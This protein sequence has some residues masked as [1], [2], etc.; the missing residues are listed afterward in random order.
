MM[1][2]AC[3]SASTVPSGTANSIQ[4][5]K[6]CQALGQVGGEVRLWLPGEC[7]VGWEALAEQ[8]GLVT[9][10][11]VRWLAARARLRRYDFAWQALRAARAWGAQAVY[12]WVPQAAL[13]ALWMGLPALLELHDRPTGKVGPWL[14]RQVARH[15]GR[16]RLLFITR[17]LQTALE[18]EQGVKVRPGEAI[19][20]PDGVDVERYPAGL[21]APEARRS[22]GLP[23]GITAGY[24]GHLY[25]GRGM[26][27]LIALAQAYPGVNFLWIGGRPNDV[28]QWRT[29]AAQMGLANLTL[30]GFVPNRQIPLYQAAGDI[31]L[32]PYETSVSVSGGGNT[33]DVCSPMKMF[34]YMAA[35]RAILSSDLPVLHEVLDASRAV[36]C[37]PEDPGAWVETFG[38]LMRDP[39]RRERLGAAARAAVGA[40]SWQERA[41]R[42][43]EE[44]R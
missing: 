30:T 5:M 15:P 35:G 24:T 19:I 23:E 16:K 2:I 4:A 13:M 18:R 41:R 11:E 25:P 17:A 27:V 10:F 31:L 12:T 32:M 14:F 38:Q 1:K 29:R 39:A 44:F 33:A 28:V 40:Y 36:F 9:P 43:L 3:I 34:E 6:V 7:S 42:C 8:Y 21:S 20:A 37:P 26:D 22:L